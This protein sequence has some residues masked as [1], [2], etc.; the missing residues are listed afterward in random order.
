[1]VAGDF[2]AKHKDIWSELVEL[3][4]EFGLSWMHNEG[5]DTYRRAQGYRS[6]LDLWFVRSTTLEAGKCSVKISRWYSKGW[7]EEHARVRLHLNIH[8]VA[9]G[10][11]RTNALPAAAINRNAQ[12]FAVL[13]R[14]IRSLPEDCTTQYLKRLKSIAW[15]WFRGNREGYLEKKRQVLMLR[16]YLKQAG[17]RVLVPTAIRG[18]VPGAP[19]NWASGRSVIF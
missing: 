1:M 10:G 14:K 9:K 6:T 5:V 13:A 16:K 18:W 7:K 12:N 8:Q 17:P 19:S 2:N 4:D 11:N 15:A 3:M